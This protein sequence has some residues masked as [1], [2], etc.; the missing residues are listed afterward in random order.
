MTADIIR[1][2]WREELKLETLSDEDD[3]FDLGGHSLIMA[4]IQMRLKEAF[5]VEVPMDV[6]LRH[7]SVREISDHLKVDALAS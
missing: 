2:I 5:G 7:A 6:L 3:F 4:N 1:A